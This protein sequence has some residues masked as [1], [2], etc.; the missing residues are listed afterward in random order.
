[1]GAPSHSLYGE[2]QGVLL[3]D[4][5]HVPRMKGRATGSAL[6]R[7]GAWTEQDGS[8]AYQAQHAEKVHDVNHGRPQACSQ[9]EGITTHVGVGCL[10]GESERSVVARKAGNA[11]G[12]KGP[13]FRE[14]S[15]KGEDRAHPLQGAS[16]E[17]EYRA[18]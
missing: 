13:H 6:S 4:R 18:P 2:G 17:D 15:L 9:S 14:A 3:R 8:P 12:A 5:R 16:D 7:R 10:P 1:L 11:A